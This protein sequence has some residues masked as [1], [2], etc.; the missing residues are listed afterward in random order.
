MKTIAIFSV[1][2]FLVTA[3]ITAQD[4][5]KAPE[6]QPVM[7]QELKPDNTPDTGLLDR[8]QKET[9]EISAMKP[10]LFIAAIIDSRVALHK[11]EKASIA[12]A[13]TGEA[14]YK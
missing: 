1:L 7:Q 6:I 3:T 14:G 9:E 2:F 5:N 11:L 12:A 10:I 8:L 4:L 13:K